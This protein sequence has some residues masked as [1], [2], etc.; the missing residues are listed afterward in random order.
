MIILAAHRLSD[1]D[2]T[3]GNGVTLDLTL[4]L[5]LPVRAHAQTGPKICYLIQIGARGRRLVSASLCTHVP[6][7]S[8]TSD[9]LPRAASR[10]Y[11]WRLALTVLFGGGGCV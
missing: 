11:G 3:Q 5:T 6:V 1:H 7:R 8:R 4:A 10:L 9:A 2:Q